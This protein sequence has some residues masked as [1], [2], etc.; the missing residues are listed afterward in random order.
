ML[1]LFISISF[2]DAATPI[3][4]RILSPVLSIM[5]LGG[6]SAIWAITQIL[7]KPLVRLAFL[8]FLFLSLSVKTLDAIHLASII[9]KNGLG[10]TARQWQESESIA[11]VRS[12]PNNAII[13]SNGIDV[14]SF[15]TGKQALSL[16]FKTSSNTQMD[17]DNFDEE[18]KS[19]CT[20]I[21]EN[22]AL[23]V[24][25]KNITW[26]WY[27]PS[28]TEIETACDLPIRK[29]FRDGTVYGEN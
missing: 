17:N 9:Q 25:F 27:L 5:I 22:G 29:H 1:F 3:D 24:Y 2:F 14:I 16:P 12:T 20:N 7:D 4:T 28:Q 18:I 8:L 15:L 6:F 13:Y 11:F 21:V 26:R 10:Y 23:L 19:M